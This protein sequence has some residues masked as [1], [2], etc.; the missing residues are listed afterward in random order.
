MSAIPSP[1]TLPADFAR[2]ELGVEKR[3][4]VPLTDLNDDE[5]WGGHITIGTPP[6]SFFVDFDTGSSD[7]WVPSA[8][9]TSSPCSGKHKYNATTSTTSVHKSGK[10]S[11]S[12]GD[13]SSVSGPVYTD[14]VTVAGIT[15][16]NQYFSPVTTLS[17]SFEDEAMTASSAW[18]SP[19]SRSSAR[20]RISTAQ[21]RRAQ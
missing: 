3:Q 1:A 11:I 10:F 12:Y 16:K 5:E 21:R 15:V 8:N 19:R 7:L 17:S 18:R 9:C 2:L 14:T 4:K 6:V 13:G 20:T